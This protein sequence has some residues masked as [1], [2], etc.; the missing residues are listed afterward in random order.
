[1]AFFGITALGPQEMYK[2]ARDDCYDLT[3][4]QMPGEFS[5]IPSPSFQTYY[6]YISLLIDNNN[7][8]LNHFTQNLLVPLMKQ[9]DE[10]DNFL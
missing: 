6:T 7:N 9:L 5:I 8:F 4:F 1:M 3:L 2:A 10:M